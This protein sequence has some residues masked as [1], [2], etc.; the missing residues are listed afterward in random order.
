MTTA[1]SI[2]PTGADKSAASTFLNC[3]YDELLPMPSADSLERLVLLGWLERL[4]N[5]CLAE[6]DTLKNIDLYA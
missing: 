2:T 1:T 6:T 5:G 4:P 3:C